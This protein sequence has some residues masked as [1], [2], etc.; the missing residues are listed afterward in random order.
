MLRSIAA[1]SAIIPLPPARNGIAIRPTA[2]KHPAIAATIIS[3][4]IS[5][6]TPSRISVWAIPSRYSVGL[7]DGYRAFRQWEQQYFVGDNWKVRS[8][9]TISAGLRYQPITGPTDTSHVT[10]TNYQ[11]DCTTLRPSLAC[12]AASSRRHPSRRLW[13][14]VWRNLSADLAAAAL[15]PSWFLKV[16][17]P[18]PQLLNPLANTYSTGARHT[19]F[20]V[21][22]ISKRPIRTNTASPGIAAEPPWK[23]N[24][25]YREPHP[26]ALYDVVQ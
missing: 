8:N 6:A 3:A 21:R 14:A 4:A 19:E 13:L 26:Q 7:G 2:A 18:A 1:K 20:D 17:V 22:I 15:G 11:C 24:E 9:F 16:E 12:L 25:L 10:P 23:S 5:A